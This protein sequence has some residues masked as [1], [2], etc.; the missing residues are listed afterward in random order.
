[1]KNEFIAFL[2]KHK[3]YK[4]YAYNLRKNRSVSVDLFLDSIEPYRYLYAAFDWGL[5]NESYA[6]WEKLWHKWDEIINN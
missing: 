1:M 6:Y 2:K 5:V 3:A 4:K